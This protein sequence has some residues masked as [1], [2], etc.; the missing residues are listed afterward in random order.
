[1]S[2]LIV[3]ET[4]WSFLMLD[5]VYINFKLKVTPRFS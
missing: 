5:G 2:L 1:M 3:L 4:L